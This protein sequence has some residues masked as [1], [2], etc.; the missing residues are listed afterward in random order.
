MEDLHKE[1]V[2]YSFAVVTASANQA[3]H[4]RVLLDEEYG[5]RAYRNDPNF[6]LMGR[7]GTHNVV[8]A[9]LP[10]VLRGDLPASEVTKDMLGTF[11]GVDRVLLVGIECR[12]HTNRNVMAW[13]SGKPTGGEDF[14]KYVDYFLSL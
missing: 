13:S 1:P 11:Y 10:M 5:T 7:K 6:Y 9:T 8:L 12:I 3:M 14:E 4:F 2:G